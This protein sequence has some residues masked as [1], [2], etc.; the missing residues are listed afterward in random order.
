MESWKRICAIHIEEEGK[1]SA[2]WLGWDKLSDVV[3]VYDACN[4]N[5]EVM[6]VIAEGL[7]AR[8]RWI[9]IAWEKK[10]GP[11]IEQLQKKGC[12]LLP[13][14]AEE[15]ALSAEMVGRD[16]QERMRTGR[17]KVEKRLAEWIKE[18]DAHYQESGKV[19]A[20]APLMAAT[21]YAISQLAWAKRL[22]KPAKNR[23]MAPRIAMI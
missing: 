14:P 6:A 10:A 19:P 12:N 18:F 8:G 20:A 1:V 9:P 13:D 16:L 3:T 22:Q 21:R 2:V 23:A 7:N 15:S 17:F 11:L 5:N 4:F